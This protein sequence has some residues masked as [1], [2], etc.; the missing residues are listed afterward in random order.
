[1]RPLQQTKKFKLSL[2]ESEAYTLAKGWAERMQFLYD[3]D[4]EGLFSN[5][6]LA[7]QTMEGFVESEEF[8]ALATTG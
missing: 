5:P 7:R 3:S 2:G 6:A 1:M 8:R 4:R